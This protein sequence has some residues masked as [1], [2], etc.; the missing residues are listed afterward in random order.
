M[1]LHCKDLLKLSA[2]GVL[3]LLLRGY[4]SRQ[5]WQHSPNSFFCL[6]S[7]LTF[8]LSPTNHRSGDHIKLH[9]NLWGM[10]VNT[11]FP[12]GSEVKASASNEGDPGSIPGSG[13][14]PGEGN[15]IHS[16][17]LAWRIPWTEKSMRS[18]RVRHDW[19][20]SPHLTSPY[21][22]KLLMAANLPRLYSIP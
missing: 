1:I 13:R 7:F 12:G 17:I 20:T 18:Q 14:S 3:L 15:A 11:G 6:E 8:I 22:L 9:Q 16:S 4:T 2:F 19:A 10:A 21:K 5:L